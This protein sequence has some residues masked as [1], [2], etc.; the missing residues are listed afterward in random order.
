MSDYQE[1]V[2]TIYAEFITSD[3]EILAREAVQGAAICTDWQKRTVTA[4][5][6]PTEALSF[7]NLEDT[8]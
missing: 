8:E 5:Q 6:I 7:F 4:Q 3:L 2:I 1:Y